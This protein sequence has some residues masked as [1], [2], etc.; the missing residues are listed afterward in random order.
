MNRTKR[1]KK[2]EYTTIR[3]K[4]D[5]GFSSLRQ[6]LS[7]V[8]VLVNGDMLAM[9]EVETES[10]TWFEYWYIL[11]EITWSKGIDRWCSFCKKYGISDPQ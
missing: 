3:I 4:E 2:R 10:V 5:T 7:Y 1:L 6:L 11:L 9:A 8:A